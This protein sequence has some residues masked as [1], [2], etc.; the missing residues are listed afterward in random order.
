VRLLGYGTLAATARDPFPLPPALQAGDLQLISRADCLHAYPKAVQPTDLCA[1]DLAPGVLTQPCPGDSGGPLLADTTNGPVE[2]GVT[3]WGAEVKDKK[4][5]AARLPAVWMRVSA[6]HDFLTNPN[7]V[8]APHTS[9]RKAGVKRGGYGGLTCRAPKFGGSPS[10]VSYRWGVARFPG[11][12]IPEMP[13]P[14][15]P[16]KGATKRTFKPG[17][18]THGKKIA[19]QVTAANAGGHWT[20]YSPSVAG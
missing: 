12:L 3:S 10:R 5:G 7:P 11:Q 6:Y 16:I 9:V 14:I 15:R 13:H 17:K 8:L 20:V 2:I 19:C 4:C 18:A 1:Q